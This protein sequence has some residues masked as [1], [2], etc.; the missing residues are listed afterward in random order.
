[1][2]FT[3]SKVEKKGESVKI[4]TIAKTKKFLRKKAKKCN[5]VFRCP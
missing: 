3:Y 4:F 1:M 2:C 5:S